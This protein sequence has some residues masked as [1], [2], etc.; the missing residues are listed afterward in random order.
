[1]ERAFEALRLRI[2]QMLQFRDR[3]LADISHELR[4]PLSRMAIALPLLQRHLPEAQADSV[5]G[6]KDT[7]SPA[8]GFTRYVGQIEHELGRMEALIEELLAYARGRSPAAIEQR[9]VDLADVARGLLSERAIVA[10]DRRLSIQADLAPALVLGDARLLARAIGNLVDNALKYTPQGGHLALR[11]GRDNGHSVF[12]VADDG[13]G[14]AA[15]SQE[16]LFEPFYRPDG[17]RSRQT[18]GVGMGLAIARA[19]AER[20]GGQALLESAEGKGTIATLSLP[21][22]G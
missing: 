4:G 22:Q 13:P 9:S 17:A 16:H 21:A 6:C 5:F 14:I 15:G 12:T 8:G 20:H 11:T 18:G 10:K 19:I 7:T 1:L 3:L 2:Q